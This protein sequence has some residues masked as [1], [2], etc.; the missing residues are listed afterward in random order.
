MVWLTHYLHKLWQH[1]VIA[2]VVGTMVVWALENYYAQLWQA[3]RYG[4]LF[5]LAAV[6]VTVVILYQ[7]S[8]ALWRR[9]G[10]QPKLLLGTPPEPHAG[11]ILLFSNAV[12]AAKAVEHHRYHL[13]YLCLIVTTEAITAARTWAQTGKDDGRFVEVQVR[14]EQIIGAW[15]PDEVMLAV[16]RAIRQGEDLGLAK[17]DLIC[18]VTGGTKAMTTGAIMACLAEGL[19]VQMVSAKYNEGL[20]VLGPGEVIQLRLA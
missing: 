17:A 20:K 14:E 3:E 11:L 8:R 15:D 13:R 9:Y 16:G 7:V 10:P 1:P 12:T 4:R 19:L 2:L 18:D 5:T 6:V